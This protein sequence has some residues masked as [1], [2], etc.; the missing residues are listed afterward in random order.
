MRAAAVLDHEL[1]AA[2]TGLR[3]DDPEH[4]ILGDFAAIAEGRAP[5]CTC[6]TCQELDAAAKLRAAKAQDDG[7]C[8]ICDGY[9]VVCSPEG[10]LCVY[11]G[12][13]IGGLLD[14]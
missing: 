9:R 3:W 4:D 7:R 5:T 2:V 1:V 11:F 8:P 12:E 10:R 14:G 6:P 13:G